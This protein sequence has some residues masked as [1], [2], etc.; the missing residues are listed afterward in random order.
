MVLQIRG[1]LAPPESASLSCWQVWPLIGGRA[2][3]VQRCPL[4]VGGT[5]RG[6]VSSD[7]FGAYIFGSRPRIP[8]RCRPCAQAP[9]A[10]AGTPLP[11]DPAHRMD[12]EPGD[13]PC[14]TAWR[15]VSNSRGSRSGAARQSVPHKAP[16][17]FFAASARAAAMTKAAVAP[18]SGLIAYDVADLPSGVR[19]LRM[20]RS[21]GRSSA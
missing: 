8:W 14:A 20:S 9:N 15:C 7:G 18:R 11:D 19:C 1:L 21:A 17:R 12:Q 2:M 10:H 3:L 13:A 4:A 6:C 5:P 16:Y